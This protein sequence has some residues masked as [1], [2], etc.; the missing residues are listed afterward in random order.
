VVSLLQRFGRGIF[1]PYAAIL[2]LSFFPLSCK[3]QS[4]E[5][6]PPTALQSDP[7]AAAAPESQSAS[8]VYDGRVK[9]DLADMNKLV[10]AYVQ[11]T[12]TIP[13]DVQELVTSGFVRSL[14][15]PPPGKTFAI[16]PHP[17][18]YQVVL[19]DNY[20]CSWRRRL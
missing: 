6:T 10:R 18:G 8:A 16:R 9:A 20:A 11:S 1:I 2:V 12:K 3:R 15:A 13:K 4:P 5:I 19:M 14:S 7:K 17:F